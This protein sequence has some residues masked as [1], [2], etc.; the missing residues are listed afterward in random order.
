LLGLLRDAASSL[1]GADETAEVLPI[2]WVVDWLRRRTLGG[3]LLPAV[4]PRV[5]L[6]ALDARD[7]DEPDRRLA[8][9]VETTDEKGVGGPTTDPP[10]VTTAPSG[11]RMR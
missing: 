3:P 10:G 7:N 9:P 5:P 1:T 11:N 6:D 8:P 4:A 2:E